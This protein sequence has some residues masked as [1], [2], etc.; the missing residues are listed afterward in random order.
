M[1]SEQTERE[2]FRIDDLARLEGQAKHRIGRAL[3][4][5]SMDYHEDGT[6][7]AYLGTV[8]PTDTSPWP[9]DNEISFVNYAPVGAVTAVPDGD[10]Y[11]VEHPDR[12][13][14][15]D[16]ATRRRE[17]E[18]AHR[19]EVLPTLRS[20]LEHHQR[21]QRDDAKERGLADLDGDAPITALDLAG[22]DW[23]HLG[24]AIGGYQLASRALRVLR[25]RL[26]APPEDE[27]ER[28]AAAVPPVLNYLEDAREEHYE[29]ACEYEGFPVSEGERISDLGLSPL[30]FLRLGI[31]AGRQQ[32][33]SAAHRHL[34]DLLE[35]PYGGERR[36][37]STEYEVIREG[38][39][40]ELPEPLE[41]YA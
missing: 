24:R 23:W 12:D 11:V 27:R 34:L 13:A 18:N 39:T 6:V 3:Y 40:E 7:V 9:G 22:S 25:R 14:L 10:G 29:A 35:D 26:V 15:S 17:L 37:S 38:R 16:A 41:D 33:A 8:R 20:F 36:W 4:V 31:L 28:Y 1:T 21:L 32:V 30:E 19:S 2:S 5:H